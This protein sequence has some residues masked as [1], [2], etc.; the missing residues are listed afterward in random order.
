S[1]LS[2]A[3]PIDFTDEADLL[4][5]LRPGKD[6]LIISDQGR[7]ALFLPQVWEQLP[8]PAAFLS[9]LKAKAGL[10]ARHW[11]DTFRAD[12]FISE[13]ISPADLDDPKSI[14]SRN[15]H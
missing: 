14:W 6:G 9:H 5:G 3:A 10:P 4:A 12:R 7:R 11:S 13:G 15:R 8:E 2:K 1:V